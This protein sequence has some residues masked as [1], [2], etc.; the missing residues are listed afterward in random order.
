[1]KVRITDGAL[2]EILRRERERIDEAG[3]RAL[4]GR[5]HDRTRTQGAKAVSLQRRN[6]R[7]DK[8]FDGLHA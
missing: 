7:R 8:G 3:N 1:M 2:S 6:A 5:D 4:R